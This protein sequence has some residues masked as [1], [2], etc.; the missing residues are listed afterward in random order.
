MYA[1]NLNVLVMLGNAALTLLA[2]LA[3]EGVAYHARDT[4]VR[5]V[6]LPLSQQVVNDGLLLGNTVQLRHKAW[7]EYHASGVKI[8]SEA[9]KAEKQ[10]VED[11]VIG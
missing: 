9:K 4:E 8:G 1:G 3:A 10:E 2:M 5:L 7:I 11:W 6:K